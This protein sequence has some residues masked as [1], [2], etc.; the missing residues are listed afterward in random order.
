MVKSCS[1]QH[2]LI[3]TLRAKEHSF[4]WFLYSINDRFDGRGHYTSA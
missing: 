3:I 2:L 1:L 4:G